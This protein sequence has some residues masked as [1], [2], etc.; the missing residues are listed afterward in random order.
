M[1]KQP[2]YWI[3]VLLVAMIISAD[4]AS[5]L[6]SLSLSSSSF[7][8]VLPPLASKHTRAQTSIF[9]QS[10]NTN[11]NLQMNAA[12]L[13]TTYRL[14]AAGSVYRAISLATTDISSTVVLLS[15]SIA[16]FVN[17]APEASM[18]LA[19][20]KRAQTQKLKDSK[21]WRSIVR[22]KIVGQF[23]GLVLSAIGGF[24]LGGA[25][26]CV[27]ADAAFWALGAGDVRF[28]CCDDDESE[29]GTVSGGGV[30]RAPVPGSVARVLLSINVA[31]LLS[32]LLGSLVMFGRQTKSSILLR[33]VGAALYCFGVLTQTI[34]DVTVRRRGKKERM[35]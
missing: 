1:M 13:P 14:L 30:K 22:V 34:G 25:S 18:Q 2:Y 15:T 32:T 35:R 17:L 20:A 8:R 9:R 12:I 16:A 10:T 5:S 11:S 29:G 23:M 21:A 24:A 4:V 7:T 33:K 27:A 6:A 28:Q 3:V 26:C 31:M 19:S